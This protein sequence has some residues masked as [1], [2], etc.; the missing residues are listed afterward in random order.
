MNVYLLGASNPE[1][2]RVIGAVER[3]SPNVKFRGML[4]NDP[5][6]KGLSF[7]GL[8]ILGGVEKV[9]DLKGDNVGFVNLITRNTAVRHKTTQSI[10]D[11]GGRLVNLIHPSIDLAMTEIGVGVYL[12]E[13]VILQA[14]V[15]IGDNTS[16]HMA[17]VVGHES[18]IGSSVFIAHAVS[19]SGC[20]KVGDGAF[21]G[22]NATVLPRINIGRWATIGAGAVVTKDVPD[23]SVVV[24]NP[25]KVVKTN[26]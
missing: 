21:I 5:E 16:I 15:Q 13:S 7:Y 23:Y 2:M 12:Q 22:T 19:I 11:A 14:G 25:G 3:V 17:S 9:S 6:K 18:K 10:I 4:D 26:K 1:T 24:G 8:P 20:C